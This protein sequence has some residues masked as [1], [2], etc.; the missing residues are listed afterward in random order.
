M[1]LD[2]FENRASNKEAQRITWKF[3]AVAMVITQIISVS[4][5]LYIMDKRMVVLKPFG[6]DEEVWVSSTDASEKYIAKM[7]NRILGHYLIWTPAN[8]R[9]RY[10]TLLTVYSPESFNE[11]HAKFYE[12]IDKVEQSKEITSVFFINRISYDASKKYIEV[13]GLRRLEG[14]DK[15]EGNE[16]YIINFY[17]YD[18]Q[19]FVKNIEQKK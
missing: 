6:L 10:D 4:M 17:I 16:T 13:S 14:H 11:A 8:I 5:T 1:E 15:F 2:S 9:E 19:M 7:A 3:I 12:I 18:G